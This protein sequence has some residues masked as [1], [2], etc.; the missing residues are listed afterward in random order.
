MY[1]AFILPSI[2]FVYFTLTNLKFYSWCANS[3]VFHLDT[4]RGFSCTLIYHNQ[5][6]LHTDDHYLHTRIANN[7]WCGTALCVRLNACLSLFDSDCSPQIPSSAYSH[8]S[9]PFESSVAFD[10]HIAHA[11]GLCVLK[12]NILMKVMKI[13]PGDRS[14]QNHDIVIVMNRITWMSIYL[15]VSQWSP[16]DGLITYVCAHV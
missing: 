1:I 9:S 14:N 8:H 13:R 16:M 6:C 15:M 12:C 4:Q 7:L 3:V 5:V 10:T 11:Y 2:R